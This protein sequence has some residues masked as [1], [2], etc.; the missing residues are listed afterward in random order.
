MS[1]TEATRP[2]ESAGPH[3]SE[4]LL[5][6]QYLVEAAEGDVA[7][8]ESILHDYL[9][10]T[11]QQLEELHGALLAQDAEAVSRL[12]HSVKGASA[13]VGALRVMEAAAHLE[14][15]VRRDGMSNADEQAFLVTTE[16]RRL[17][18][19]LSRNG[20]AVLMASSRLA[21]PA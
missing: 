5:D 17:E 11:G 16:F 8:I 21:V 13:S 18:A 4:E 3:L 2:Q 14:E 20:E 12:A 7:F 1:N 19:Y 6:L 15:C 9:K 10:G